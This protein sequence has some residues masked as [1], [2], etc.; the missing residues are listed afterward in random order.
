M[1]NEILKVPSPKGEHPKNG[2]N[3]LS[4]MGETP[5]P[6]QNRLPPTGE[7]S[8]SAKKPPSLVGESTNQQYRST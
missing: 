1:S 6:L 2:K 8:F 3:R 5:N 7:T 4:T